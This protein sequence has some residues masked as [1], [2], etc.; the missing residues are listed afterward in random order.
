M[1]KFDFGVKILVNGSPTDFFLDLVE[2][3]NLYSE[4]KLDLV[5]LRFMFV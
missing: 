4:L 2:C 1:L 3:G 5:F